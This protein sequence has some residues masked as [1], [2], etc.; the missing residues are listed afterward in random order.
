[1]RR[2]VKDFLIVMHGK[3]PGMMREGEYGSMDGNSQSG[4]VRRLF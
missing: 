3:R 1:V 4:E 2:S